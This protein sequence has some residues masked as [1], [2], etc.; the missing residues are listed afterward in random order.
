MKA[1]TETK[2]DLRFMR[3]V[4]IA[5][6]ILYVVSLPIYLVGGSIS[7][8]I[9]PVMSVLWIL[10]N[11]VF[12]VFIWRMPLS[13]KDKIFETVMICLFGL[14]AMW[15]WMQFNELEDN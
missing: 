12:I 11:I 9:I 8:Y 3:K 2:R 6:T 14:L 4:L 1:N 5:L 7:V 13:R 10:Y 15:A